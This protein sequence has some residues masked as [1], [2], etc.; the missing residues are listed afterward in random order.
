MPTRHKAE[1]T[2][3]HW[4]KVANDTDFQRVAT[5]VAEFAAGGAADMVSLF[6]MVKWMNQTMNT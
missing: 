3:C 4:R 5:G 6:V 1:L 2:Q